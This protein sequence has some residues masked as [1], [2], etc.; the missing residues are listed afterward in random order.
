MNP[1]A[2]PSTLFT[3]PPGWHW[4]IIGY[5]F[6]GGLAGGCFFLA[7]LIDLLGRP[8]DRPLARIGYYVAFPAVVLSA[9]FLTFDLG[10]PLRFWHMLIESHAGRPMFKTY[11]P[12][13][14]G[15]WALLMFGLFAFLAFLGALA[16]TERGR[17]WPSLRRL[18]PPA[19]VG[20]FVAIVGG[21]LG[22]FVAGYTGV[23]LT[24][25]NRPIWSDTTLL[26]LNF[27]VSAAS[28][29]AAL[30]ALLGRRRWGAS[31]GLEALERFDAWIL[32]LEFVALLGL[33]LSLGSM[34]HAWLN[35]WGALLAVGVI[36]LG[37]LAPLVLYWR[38]RLIAGGL[39]TAVAAVLVLIGGFI[40]RVV[41]VLSSEGI[42]RP[43]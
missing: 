14:L 11:S 33:M 16:D 5:F 19:F 2:W 1:G 42:G 17:R 40:F 34:L 28:T 35:A 29:S 39:S 25:T 27:L 21:L 31:A 36:V 8:T 37:I 12:M 26:G 22:F 23:L 15:S 6:V 10:R 13:S 4:L 32:I 30:L 7:A 38:P 24:V 9:I 20:R 3:N 43:M 41:V 18:R